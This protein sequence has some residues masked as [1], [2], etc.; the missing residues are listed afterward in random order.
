MWHRSRCTEVYS[1]PNF[2]DRQS[3]K[4]LG[5]RKFLKLQYLMYVHMNAAYVQMHTLLYT[6]FG[7]S[8]GP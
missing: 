8:V 5:V 6:Y 2:C 7:A 3:I 1:V 4:F